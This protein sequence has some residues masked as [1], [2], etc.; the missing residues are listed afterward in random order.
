MFRL[1]FSAEFRRDYRKFVREHP[2]LLDDFRESLELLRETG[3]IPDM[4]D[5]HMLSKSSRRYNGFMDFHLS[6][7][8]VD[9][10]VLYLPHATNPIIR[11]VRMGSHKDLFQ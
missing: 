8:K 7:G 3:T 6:D 10:I 1:T 2:E 4:Y 9:I 11:L 5:L